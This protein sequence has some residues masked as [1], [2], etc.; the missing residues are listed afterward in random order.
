M[1]RGAEP[2]ESVVEQEPAVAPAMVATSATTPMLRQYLEVKSRQPNALLFFRLGD[3]YELF[4]EDAKTAAEVLNITLT[5]RPKGEERIPMCGVPHHAAKGYIA[6]LVDAGFRV[7]ICDQMEEPGPGKTIVRRDI[8]RVVTPGTVFDEE[9]REAKTAT[10]LA[11]LVLENEKGGALALLE[12]STGE[13][14][15][16]V[17]ETDAALNE[18]LLRAEP[19]EILLDADTERT[20]RIAWSGVP[21]TRTVREARE[22]DSRKGFDALCRQFAVA[23]LDGFGLARAPLAWAAAASVL[24]YVEETQKS[25]LAHI[26]QITRYEPGGALLIDAASRRNLD[27]LR[28]SVDGRRT[29]SLLGVIDKTA[30][31]MGGRLLAQWVLYPLT[32]LPRIVERQDAIAELTTSAVLREDLTTTLREIADL[33]RL[34]SR[35]VV[36]QGNARD[37]KTLGLS[38]GRLPLVRDLLAVCRTPALKDA[39]APLPELTELSAYLATAL[40]EEPPATTKEGGMFRRGFH[41]ELDELLDLTASGKDAIAR[42][43]A[44]ERKRTGIQ[45]LKIRF[46]RV[47]GYFIEITKANLASVPSDYVR[48]QTTAGGERYVTPWL[49]E[50]EGKVLTAQERSIALEQKLFEELRTRAVD[51][52]AWIQAAARSLAT[53]D[54]YLSL[55]RVAT[56]YDYRRPTVNTGDLIRIIEGRHPVVE[57]A[58]GRE[59]FVPNDIELDHDHRLVVL[60]GPNMAGKSTAMR[61]VALIT[62]LAQ[63][64]SFV[65]A[66]EAVIGIADRVF[67]RVGAGDDLARGQSTFMVEMSET[68]NILR[69]ATS[70]SLVLL[71]EIGRGTSTFDGLAIAWAVAEHIHDQIRCRTI[72]ATHYHELTQ[73]AHEKEHVFNL[74]MAVKEWQDRVVFLRKL[75][76]GAASRSYGVQVAKLA[77]VPA[78]VLAR[79]REVLTNLEK[80]GVDESGHPVFARAARK[81][82]RAQLM[83]G[84]GAPPVDLPAVASS[85]VLDELATLDVNTLTPMDALQLLHRWKQG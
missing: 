17:A 35:L 70:R 23:S 43:E 73:L 80:S 71:D 78:P 60:T 32:E 45:S 14:R 81:H 33:E 65:P 44:D 53:L 2:A 51:H 36:G 84:L 75:V 27:L 28:N 79:A 83:L 72:F 85:P 58:L 82:A 41:A 30:T 26:R 57:R 49:Q 4:F 66:R 42:M 8:T 16:F 25:A 12:A 47:F 56:D 34:T 68:A 62:V 29:G 76:P 40:A 21:A 59:P 9:G 11:G 22:W 7:A 61:Q 74:T 52:A 6:R 38:L 31:A 67:T 19:R 15:V 3:F 54:V 13:F 37:L 18:E 5:S 55:A 20:D 64:G 39:L 10:W 77:G 24:R 48:K 50:Y 1:S 69:H 63:M 46:N